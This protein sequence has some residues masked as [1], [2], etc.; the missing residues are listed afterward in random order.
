MLDGNAGVFFTM[1]YRVLITLLV[2][3]AGRALRLEA[4]EKTKRRSAEAGRDFAARPPRLCT[5]HSP[6]AGLQE[7][8]GAG[9]SLEPAPGMLQGEGGRGWCPQQHRPCP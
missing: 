7:E 1:R 6:A 8:L 3:G 9:L 5:P 2:A 4:A